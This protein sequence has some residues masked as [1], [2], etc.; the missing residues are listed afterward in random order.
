MVKLAQKHHLYPRARLLLLAVQP[1]RKHLGV[2]DDEEVAGG[3]VLQDVAEVLVF[4][5]LRVAVQHHHAGV[6]ALF[7]RI[8]CYKVLW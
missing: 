1:C 5:C 3:A 6:F 2:V 8:V 7:G 4:Y